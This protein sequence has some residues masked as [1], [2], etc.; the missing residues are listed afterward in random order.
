M[1]AASVRN[2]T[3][4]PLNQLQ[5]SKVTFSRASR[6]AGGSRLSGCCAARMR[7]RA[8]LLLFL[9]GDTGVGD[10][11][12]ALRVVR[13][14]HSEHILRH[15]PPN[16]NPLLDRRR[17]CFGLR[18]LAVAFIP[19]GEDLEEP[20]HV[21]GHLPGVFIRE[22]AERSVRARTQACGRFARD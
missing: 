18:R 10:R 22:F 12:D 15:Q 3:G 4:F 20:R 9:H 8:F 11:L 14:P 21:D 13:L 5:S 16:S 19:F 6:T 17:C 7:L 2:S 1:C